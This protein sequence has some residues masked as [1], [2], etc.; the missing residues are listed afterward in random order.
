M[1]RLGLM[2]VPNT[3]NIII[4]SSCCL[5]GSNNRFLLLFPTSSTVS[6]VRLH[7]STRKF[8]IFAAREDNQFNEWELMDLK[9]GRLLGEDPKLT[10]AK[11][12]TRR[13]NPDATFIEIEKEFYKNKGKMPERKELPFNV[14]KRSSSVSSSV[15]GLNLVN[16][17]VPKKG[18]SSSLDGLNLVRPVPKKG[19]KFQTDYK[20]DLPQIRKQGGSQNAKSVVGRSSVPNVILRKPTLFNED[21]IEDER[22]KLKMKPNLTLKMR[23][24]HIN[25]KFSDMTLLRKP[26][27]ASVNVDKDVDAK[28]VSESYRLNLKKSEENEE[29]GD[30]PLLNKPEVMNVEDID[31]KD[32]DMDTKSVSESY[33]LNVKQAEEKE[34]FD[35]V[36]LLNKPELMN[37]E[38]IDVKGKDVDTKSVSESYHLSVKKP[39][40]KEEYGD[41]PHL[42][43]PEVVNVENIV[44]KDKDVDTKSVSDSYRVN[45]KKPEENEEYGDL[46]LLNKPDVMNLEDVDVKDRDL[47]TKSVS[48][49][50]G[51]NVKKS[52]EK[53]K[54]DGF[55]ILNKPEVINVQKKSG[56]EEDSVIGLQPPVPRNIKSFE[57]ETS[58]NEPMK[59]S[60]A[61]STPKLETS[62]IEKPKRLDKSMNS[63]S[64]SIVE[65]KF[66]T[67]LEIDGSSE[68]KNIQP[69]SSSEDSDWER[70]QDLAKNGERGEVELI[71]S[72]TKGFMVSF[73][74]LVG[75]MPYRNLA[76]KWKFLAF[77][78]WLRRKGLDPSIYRQNLAIIGNNDVGNKNSLANSSLDPVS[79]QKLDGT[80]SPD[81]K[82]EELLRIYDLEKLKFLQSFVGQKLNVIVITA[83]KNT[84]KLILSMRPKE[85]DEFVE[86]KKSLMK[87]VRGVKL[88]SENYSLLAVIRAWLTWARLIICCST[89]RVGN[90]CFA[91]WRKLSV[92]DFVKCCIQ[93]ITYFGIFVEIEG[94]PALIHQTEV[95]WDATLDPSSYFK[96]GQIVEAKVHQL[97]F[98]LGRIFLSMKEITPDPLT[99][100]LESVV[101]GRDPLDGKLQIA[102]PDT[103]WP[104]VESLI[105][106]LEKI[107]GIQSVSK[108]GFFLSP[109]LAPT[110][111]VYMTASFENQYKLL[112]RS[113]NKVQEVIVESSLSKEEMKSTILSCASRVE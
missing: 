67:S 69:I 48:D 23:D 68:V 27:P 31:V 66:P 64:S 43:K 89:R 82:L 103:E 108:G 71:S 105:K 16:R 42:N 37:V 3:S 86:K 56:Q 62:L 59:S 70:A 44:G 29:Y 112:A 60:L 55:R 81:M 12:I 104:D 49:S 35:D 22:T 87:A 19:V 85:K 34:E 100:S 8:A 53:E 94:V 21:D 76:S 2:K 101:G 77:E 47:D 9:F 99:E 50:Y 83:D 46:P 106:E 91:Y 97:D 58:I 98:S 84:R 113:E 73:G 93:K 6:S 1:E 54:Y 61:G 14:D 51:L 5:S 30:L 110:F 52:E 15:D 33:R 4:P 26:A 90:N 18:V 78:T 17:P 109:G 7:R 25:D 32:K 63:S 96:V 45:L 92:G 107:E 24:E 57:E 28:S 102:E 79:E 75:F 36:P 13:T 72:S 20:P 39:E 38:D 10:L 88:H 40:E 111:Q 74:S 41:L 80:I 95:S 11:I 65:E